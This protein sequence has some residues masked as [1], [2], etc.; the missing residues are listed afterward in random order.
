MQVQHESN[1]LGT[2]EVSAV[3]LEVK[4]KKKINIKTVMDCTGKNKTWILPRHSSHA[5]SM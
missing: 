3:D 5:Y 1:I 4:N 2:N